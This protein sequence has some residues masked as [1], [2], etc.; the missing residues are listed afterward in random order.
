MKLSN[1]QGPKG[2]I[3]A[4]RT[5]AYLA[6]GNSCGWFLCDTSLEDCGA[7]VFSGLTTQTIANCGMQGPGAMSLSLPI[8]YSDDPVRTVRCLPNLMALIEWTQLTLSV[9]LGLGVNRD[10]RQWTAN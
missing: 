10:S 5:T 1:H 2:L 9:G 6:Q 7:T 3:A 8:A 4:N